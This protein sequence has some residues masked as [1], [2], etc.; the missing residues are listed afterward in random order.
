MD[1]RVGQKKKEVGG[2]SDQHIDNHCDS[3]GKLWSFMFMK[4]L[5]VFS[6]ERI[7]AYSLGFQLRYVHEE[8]PYQALLLCALLVREVEDAR[9]VRRCRAVLVLAPA[10]WHLGELI[11]PLGLLINILH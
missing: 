2:T 3:A 11:P 4:V 10:D 8:L 1:R 7:R 9:Q 6:C 5:T